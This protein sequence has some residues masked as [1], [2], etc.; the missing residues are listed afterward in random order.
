MPANKAYVDGSG[1]GARERDTPPLTI[2]PNSAIS[3]SET[4]KL[5]KS[6][7]ALSPLATHSASV[8]LKSP[9]SCSE[10]ETGSFV[11]SKSVD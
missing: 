6:V 1:T 5:L 7:N 2:E 9:N 8:L 11:V 4:D 10:K 3:I